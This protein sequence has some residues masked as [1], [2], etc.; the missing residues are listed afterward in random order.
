MTGVQMADSDAMRPLRPH[1]RPARV[2]LND[3]DLFSDGTAV[4]QVGEET[5]RLV[6]GNLADG[7]RRR[8]Y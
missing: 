6:R 7:V 4:K 5:L 8:G 1:R 2:R 3:V